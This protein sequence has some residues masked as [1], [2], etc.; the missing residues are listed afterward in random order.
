MELTREEMITVKFLNPDKV[1]IPDRML[2][3]S[4]TNQF[5]R[6]NHRQGT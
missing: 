2:R 4:Q 3:P 1:T 6:L 5:T